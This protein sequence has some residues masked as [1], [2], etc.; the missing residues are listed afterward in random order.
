M[1]YDD[2]VHG[3]TVANAIQSFHFKDLK[4]KTKRYGLSDP[5]YDVKGDRLKLSTIAPERLAA[6]KPGA[7]SE[8]AE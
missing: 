8:V 2:R 6:C 5:R 3:V 4:G 1:R 7:P